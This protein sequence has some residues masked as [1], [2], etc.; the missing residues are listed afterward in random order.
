MEHVLQLKAG[1]TFSLSQELNHDQILE[2]SKLIEL[3]SQH[4]PID[5]IIGSKGFY[6][7]EFKVSEDVLSPR[8]D[9]EILLENAINII[10]S[11]N[12]PFILELGVGSGCII[13]SL[14]KEN[15]K[16]KGIGIDISVKA[17]AIAEENAKKL[18][19][20]ERLTLINTS[21]FNDDVIKNIG[22][23]F[24]IIVSNPPYIKSN[25]IPL[26]DAEVKNFDPLIALDGGN[27]G[28]RDY[29][30]ISEISHILLKND[31]FLLFEIGENQAQDVINIG[32]QHHFFPCEIVRDLNNIDRCII[33]KK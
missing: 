5:K 31:G 9:T 6:K 24:D 22:N 25:E 10:K 1:Q 19:V 7:Y 21:W 33:L 16:A 15:R 13:T 3:R 30:R 20:D 18:C 17:L 23:H 27:D 32:K 4:K 12:N 8:P 28:L 2:F 14:L 11:K 29:R 26:L